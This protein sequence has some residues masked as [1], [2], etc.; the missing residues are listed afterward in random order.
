MPM[1]SFNTLYA[2]APQTLGV[3]WGN[4]HPQLG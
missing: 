1:D 3:L 4:L 2:K